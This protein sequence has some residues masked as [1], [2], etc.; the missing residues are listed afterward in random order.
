MAT[1]LPCRDENDQVPSAP[2]EVSNREV[3]FSIPPIKITKVGNKTYS[4]VPSQETRCIFLLSSVI[5]AVQFIY[6]LYL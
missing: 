1:S 2:I 4:I 3:T 6:T 5:P